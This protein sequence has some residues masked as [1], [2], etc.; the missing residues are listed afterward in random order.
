MSE[1]AAAQRSTCPQTAVRP[2]QGRRPMSERRRSL[3]RLEISREAVR[4]FREQGVAATSGEQIAAGVG[5]SV[6]TLRRY[7]RTKESCVE[8]LLTLSVDAFVDTLRRWPADKSLEAHLFTDHRPPDRAAATDDGATLAVVR[9]S[10]EEPA[11]RAI[12][13]AVHARAEPV[14]AEIIAERL[15]RDPQELAIRVQAATLNAA[16]RITAEDLA[17]A[18]GDRTGPQF[19]EDGPARLSEAVRAAIRGVIGDVLARGGQPITEL[20]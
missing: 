12:W 17:A 10:R 9:M 15:G 7:F 1:A 8:P 2:G 6:R 5:L 11:L 19:G 4:L 14:L 18:V 13:L 16:L 3:Q 20:Q